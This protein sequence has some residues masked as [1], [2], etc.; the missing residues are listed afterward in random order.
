MT[1][2]LFPKPPIFKCTQLLACQKISAVFIVFNEMLYLATLCAV[3][4]WI[5]EINVGE[6]PRP[7]DTLSPTPSR[8]T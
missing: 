5:C 1:R 6:F 8:S 2:G 7:S 4:F 3:S